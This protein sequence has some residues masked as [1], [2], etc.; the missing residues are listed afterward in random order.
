[1]E[2][3]YFVCVAEGGGEG[4]RGCWEGGEVCGWVGG[5]E[6]CEEGDLS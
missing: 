3:G 2:G 6:G 4:G 1:M 5:E